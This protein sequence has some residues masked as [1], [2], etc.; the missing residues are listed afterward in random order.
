MQCA[1]DSKGIVEAG[2]KYVKKNFL[3]LRAFRDIHD[4]NAQLRAWVMSEAGNRV[5]GTTREAPLTRFAS[6]EQ[7]LELLERAAPSLR[8]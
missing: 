1:L 8:A 6:V 3:P 5:H 7:A 2:V 4:A